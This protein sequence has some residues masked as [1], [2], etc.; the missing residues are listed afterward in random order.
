MTGSKLLHTIRYTRSIDLSVDPGLISHL[1]IQNKS[2]L[3]PKLLF[4]LST[5][6]ILTLL[7]LN[8]KIHIIDA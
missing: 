5:M 1:I 2:V 8:S 7:I 3:L 6:N 4:N